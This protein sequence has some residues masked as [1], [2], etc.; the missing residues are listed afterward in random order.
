MWLYV[1][2]CIL[3]SAV[4]F[5]LLVSALRMKIARRTAERRERRYARRYMQMITGS[6][7]NGESVPM[8]RFPMCERSGAK[9]VLAQ[10]LAAASASTC[11]GE[12]AGA[13]RR[14]VAANGIEGWLLRRVRHS[15]GYTRARYLAMLS[16][17]PV[18]HTTAEYLRRYSSD[19]ERLIRFRTM[20]VE[21]AAEP[22]SAVRALSAYPYPMT[23][24]EMA[25]LTSM[26]RRGLL[27]LAYAPL[28]SS[29][30]RNLRMLGLNIV[31]IFGITEAEYL[32][33]NLLADDDA[34]PES[35]E[36]H[37]ETICVL[38]S[39]H[40]PVSHRRTVNR[41]RTLTPDAR[42]ALFRRLVSEGYSVAVL[43]RLADKEEH[44]YIESLAASYKR[45]LVCH[46]Q[47]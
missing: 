8:A 15:H 19:K 9:A 18:S 23:H 14:M 42:R 27:P 34:T 16:A 39:L 10:L 1:S 17:L 22:S 46:F 29:S 40:L 30:N 41:I 28:L 33:R 20:L 21:I 24:L 6:M 12:P 45:T 11:A 25:E 35:D 13:V 44:P 36:I 26:L 31:R 3:C 43:M 47:M 38:V 2:Y 4:T 37:Y 7:L 5:V 32:L